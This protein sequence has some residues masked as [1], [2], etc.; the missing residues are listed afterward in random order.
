MKRAVYE[1]IADSFLGNNTRDSKGKKSVIQQRPRRRVLYLAVISVITLLAAFFLIRPALYH[2]N[3]NEASVYLLS[4]RYP[5]SL[6]Y[7]LEPDNS[8]TKV[9]S[10]ALAQTNAGI[11]KYLKL[12]IKAD[13]LFDKESGFKIAVE[14]AR[15]EKSFYYVN[16]IT[17]QW[18]DFTIE[19][20]RF[21][22]ISDW[23][24]I[25]NI[26]FV[27]E[28]WNIYTKKGIIYIDNVRF[29]E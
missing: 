26:S 10:Y 2:N 25:I 22:N 13:K 23:S 18:Q 4:A 1:E 14:N 29:S 12:R 11:F 8:E 3:I 20:S 7:S 17:N 16:G 5:I 15:R 6:A 21:K 19:L 27:L 28:E 9:F 24:K